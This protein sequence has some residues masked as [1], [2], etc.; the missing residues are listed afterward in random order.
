MS[1]EQGSDSAKKSKVLL[2]DDR[3]PCGKHSE[4]DDVQKSKCYKK[5]FN[6][7]ESSKNFKNSEYTQ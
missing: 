7:P 6:G 2:T 5:V 4:I 1:P 3:P